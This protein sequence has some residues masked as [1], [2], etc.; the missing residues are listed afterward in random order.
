MWAMM[1]MLRRRARSVLA[2]SALSLPREVGEGLV[3]FRHLVHSLALFHG[4]ALAV[5][6]RNQLFGQFQV[7]G[8][9]LLVARG[10]DEPA[11][12]ERLLTIALHLHRHLVGGSAHALGADLDD[13]LSVVDGL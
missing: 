2:I 3:R 5:V 1:R 11:E 7:H 6:G 13:G 8:A 10:V 4:G 12:G 9:A